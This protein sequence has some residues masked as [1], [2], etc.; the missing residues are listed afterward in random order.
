LG[1]LHSSS[2][3]AKSLQDPSQLIAGRDLTLSVISAVAESANK[4]IAVHTCPGNKKDPISKIT[5]AKMAGGMA[6]EVD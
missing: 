1:G 5:R 6:Q 2:A 4:M 3:Q